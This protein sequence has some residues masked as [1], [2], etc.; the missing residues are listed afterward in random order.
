MAN[1]MYIQLLILAAW[2]SYLPLNHSPKLL[3]V[4]NS[5][6]KWDG[7]MCD[8]TISNK[9]MHKYL[10]ILALLLDRSKKITRKI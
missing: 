3:H 9:L 2:R 4:K 7:T 8:L 6:N 5:N 10:Q 1:N